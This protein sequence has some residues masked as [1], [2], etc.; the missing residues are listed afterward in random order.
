MELFWKQGYAATSPAQI[1]SSL[2]ISR[3]SLYAT[4]VDKRNLFIRSL[5]YY[6]STRSQG[7][8]EKI[9]SSDNT[10]STLEEIFRNV[11]NAKYNEMNRYGCLV[12][13]TA[14]EFGS[15]ETDINKILEDNDQNIIQALTELIERSQID[16]CASNTALPSE[17][18]RYIYNNIVGLRVHMRMGKSAQDLDSMSSIILAT[19]KLYI[20]NEPNN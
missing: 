5:K 16:K 1:V 17:L 14:I 7:L 11:I 13:N 10:I 15:K 8:I 20:R 12:V 6:I 4:Y 9:Q 19:L 2:G 18:A 3:S